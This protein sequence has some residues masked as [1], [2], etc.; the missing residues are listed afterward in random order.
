[1]I[2]PKNEEI[3][4]I[5]INK[6]QNHQK[7]KTSDERNDFISKFIQ[8]NSPNSESN[9]L[10]RENKDITTFTKKEEKNKRKII[11]N[12]N[13]NPLTHY[14]ID[15]IE[16]QNIINDEIFS[17]FNSNIDSTNPK[18]H[19]SQL[20]YFLFSRLD[21]NKTLKCNIL[22]NN[23]NF[24]LYSHKQKFIL[25]AKEEFSIFHKN[26][27]IYTSRDFTDLSVVARLHSYSNKNEFILYDTGVSPSKL[28]NNEEINNNKNRLRRYLLQVN[29][30]NNKKYEHFLVYLPK[31]NYFDNKIF[32]T[33]VS[34][35]DKLK[36]GGF[37]NINIYENTL[38]TFDF[39][40]HKFVNNFSYRVKE[41]SKFN[42]K[43][44]NEEIN[45]IEC[46]KVNDMNY[47]L[48]ISY[49]F[50]PLEAFAIAISIF[51]K[52]K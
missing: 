20:L 21:K 27:N 42:F 23:N 47:I 1:M 35:K 15:R 38:P 4:N 46:G 11:I 17:Y 8:T 50:S 10:S 31:D 19:Q 34:N 52:N 41:K 13:N 44:E 33:D 12:N 16:P 7:S 32:N 30:L 29:Y 36:E 45:A 26:F 37:N 22:L 51:I 28:K 49:P 40:L 25:S 39:N 24:I 9:F 2:Y 48:D 3:I 18:F 6:K 5:S 43:I 14:N